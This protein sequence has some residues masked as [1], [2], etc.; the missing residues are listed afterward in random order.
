MQDF[1]DLF[2]GFVQHKEVSAGFTTLGGEHRIID[3]EL[4]K[5]LGY[6]RRQHIRKMIERK[7]A[8]LQE[9]GELISLPLGGPSAPRYYYLTCA[10]STFLIRCCKLPQAGTLLTWLMGMINAVKD[11]RFKS[12]NAATT[13][14]LQDI[15]EGLGADSVL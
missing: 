11:G 5:A 14:F 6:A 10:Q 12:P 2:Y 9:L 1:A 13:I 8:I 3:T 4:G 15:A 7:S